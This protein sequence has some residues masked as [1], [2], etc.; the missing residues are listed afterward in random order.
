MKNKDEE[1]RD[2]INDLEDVKGLY[3]KTKKVNLFRKIIE[4]QMDFYFAQMKESVL[5]LIETMYQ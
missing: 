2:V 3:E 5:S 1:V 4:H